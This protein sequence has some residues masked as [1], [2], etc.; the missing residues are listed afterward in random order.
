MSN[1]Q[2][3]PGELSELLKSLQQIQKM[4][5]DINAKNSRPLSDDEV[6]DRVG[7]NDYGLSPDN[8]VILSNIPFSAAF[9]FEALKAIPSTYT[10]AT[11]SKRMVGRL[12]RDSILT[13]IARGVFP[14]PQV[15]GLEKTRQF[16]R[17]QAALY[18]LW[19]FLPS[20][21]LLE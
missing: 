20:L 18:L 7:R 6:K 9:R 1:K 11:I 12:R 3:T 17:R 16:R 15:A 21:G 10:T 19:C 5:S 4:Q 8:P 13:A 2:L 14:F